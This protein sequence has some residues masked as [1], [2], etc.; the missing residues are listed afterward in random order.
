MVRYRNIGVDFNSQP[1]QYRVWL[2]DDVP[3]LTGAQYTGLKSGDNALMD[4]STY[5]IADG[6]AIVDFSLPIGTQWYP[7][8]RVLPA[9]LSDSQIAII[10]GYIYAFGGKITDKI[11]QASLNNPAT[12]VDTGATL[13]APLYNSSLAVVNDTIYLFGG[14]TMDGYAMDGYG[15]TNAIFSASVSDPLIWTNTNSALPI[16]LHSSSLGMADGYLFLAGG[17]DYNEAADVILMAAISDPVNWTIAGALP[18]PLYGATIFQADGYW[19]LLGGQTSSNIPTNVIYSASVVNPLIWQEVGNLPY[20]TSY[21]Q[22]LVIGSNAYYIGSSSGGNSNGF[23]TILQS[24]FTTPTVWTDTRQVV[25]AVL[26]HSQSGIIY[27]RL[28][29]FGGSGLSAIFACEQ[30]VKYPSDYP[31]AVDYGNITRTVLQSA[32]NLNQPFLALGIPWWKTSYTL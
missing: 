21:G 15:A 1:Q 29:F 28:W 3:D 7:T 32:D 30:L 8:Y 2:T 14:N 27:D 12:W 11:Y 5:L 17:Y 16:V 24:S 10:D 25:P 26:S 4:I 6:Y 18:V 20:N 31:A 19:Y 13:P 22:L 23:T 9:E